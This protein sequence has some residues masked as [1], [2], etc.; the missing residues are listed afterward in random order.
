MVYNSLVK[1]DLFKEELSNKKVYDLIVSSGVFLEGHI[2]FEMVDIL[3]D[4]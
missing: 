2:S 4:I 1:K 3:L